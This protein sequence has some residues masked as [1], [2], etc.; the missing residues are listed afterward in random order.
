MAQYSKHLR[1]LK[2]H[3][4]PLNE[5]YCNAPFDINYTLLHDVTLMEA[6]SFTMNNELKRKRKNEDKDK[7]EN[8]IDKIQNTSEEKEIRRLEWLEEELQELEDEKDKENA[9][10]YFAK[11]NLE[12]ERPTKF[13]CSMNKKMKDKAQFEVFHVKETDKIGVETVREITKQKEVEWE[14]RKY[15]CKLY[16]KE[17]TVIDKKDILEMTGQVKK[18]SEAEKD[19][20]EKQLQRKRSARL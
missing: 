10:R 9:K 8:E 14:V 18:I 20:L 17:E 6:R 5:Q 1:Q 7:L 11:N 16:R 4:S 3:G 13:F 19:N 12:G 2:S 15:Y